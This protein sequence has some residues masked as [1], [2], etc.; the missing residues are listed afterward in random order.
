MVSVL[1]AIDED[2]GDVHAEIPVPIPL[3]EEGELRGWMNRM[4]S[5]AP[6]HLP[7]PAPVA[8]RPTPLVQP[9][10]GSAK[11][12]PAPE[13]PAMLVSPLPDSEYW[14]ELPP[15]TFPDPDEDDPTIGVYQFLGGDV[16]EIQPSVDPAS[17][18]PM[19][20]P[21]PEVPMRLQVVDAH[22]EWIDWGPIPGE[23][24]LVGRAAGGAEMPGFGTLAS[25]HVFFRYDDAA[26]VADDLGSYDGVYRR[27]CEPTALGEG[28]RFRIGGHVLEFRLPE[29]F[30]SSAPLTSSERGTLCSRDLEPLAFVDLVRPNGQPGLRFPITKRDATVI[31]REGPTACIALAGDHAVSTSHAQ[32]RPRD[33]AF[34][35]EDLKTRSGTFVRLAGATP[36]RAG[37]VLQVG[38][39]TLRVLEL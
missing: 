10:P 1:D 7:E 2:D 8:K 3:A 5:N 4:L 17:P 13:L 35:L 19:E 25:A 24:R 22:G 38:K 15:G 34:Y 37:D 30:V 14:S 16:I 21:P 20:V 26:L 27:I 9:K 29:P 39:M 12:L 6:D 23:G 28:Q 11:H 32:I 31:G 33:G 36:I 18:S